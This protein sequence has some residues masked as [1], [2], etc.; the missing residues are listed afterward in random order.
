M[1]TGQI[2]CP[3]CKSTDN[4]KKFSV[5][6]YDVISCRNCELAFIHPYP[7]DVE[8]HVS[9]EKNVID[10]V[11]ALDAKKHYAAEIKY[12]NK[13][14]KEL[15]PQIEQECLDA[16]SILDAGCGTGHLLKLLA[17]Y[18][19]LVRVGIE[20]DASRAQFAKEI[21]G[22]EIYQI[23]IEKFS[24]EKKFDVITL[25]NVLSHI[26]S[27]DMLFSAIHS[28][29]TEKGKLILK[30]GE[31]PKDFKK[32]DVFDWGIPQH[33]HFLCLNTI[34]VICEKY[35]FKIIK[36]QRVLLSDKLFMRERFTTFG[37]SRWKNIAKWLIAYTPFAL[38]LLKKRYESK[39]SKAYS[40]FI[41]L[42]SKY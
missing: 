30:V 17:K 35:N 7:T 39:A 38:S 10:G 13:S 15:L 21:A 33:M 9:V 29:L 14:F 25:M 40:S 4:E 20:L 16:N 32:G 31:F 8:R 26:P 37:R 23:P 18:P 3:L 41:V 27:F 1:K 12:Y 36:H 42:E 22:C 5:N 19:N 2:I 11:S 24:K 34:N 28:L 6:N